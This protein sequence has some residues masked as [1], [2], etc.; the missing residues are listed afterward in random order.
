VT[1]HAALQGVRHFELCC[2]PELVE[3]YVPHGFSTDVG[4][5]LFL[6]KVRADA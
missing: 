2:L 3:F 5:T 1:G 6:R 4:N